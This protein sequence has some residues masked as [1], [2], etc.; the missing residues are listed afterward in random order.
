VSITLY[1]DLQG[2][3]I[4]TYLLG[5][6]GVDTEEGF[7]VGY[8]GHDDISEDEED[9][10]EIIPVKTYGRDACFASAAYLWPQSVYARHSSDGPFARQGVTQVLR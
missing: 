3:D 1:V 8:V 10:S 6:V 4:D 2:V 7:E 5:E 9:G